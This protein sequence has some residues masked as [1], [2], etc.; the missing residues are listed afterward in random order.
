VASRL[1][2]RRRDG[3]IE[4]KINAV[5]RAI[6][7]EAFVNVLKA[8]Q[9]PSHQW[10]VSLNGPIDPS[11]DADNPLAMFSRQNEISTNAELAG[12]TVEDNFLNDAEGWAWLTTLQVALRSTVQSYGI[13]DDEKW[14]SAAAE[15]R[16]YVENLQQL[17]FELADVL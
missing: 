6:L 16:G 10:H 9:D 1:F 12:V 3:R 11:Q 13:L 17:L 15:V 5:G 7:K 14:A 2:V 4:V 8:E